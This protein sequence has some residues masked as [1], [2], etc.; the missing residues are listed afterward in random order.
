MCQRHFLKQ[1]IIYYNADKD[2]AALTKFKNWLLIFPTHQN[3]LGSS[4]NSKSIYVNNGKVDEY[5][6]WV[7]TLS[8]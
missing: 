5:A 7:K 6:S 8:L 4:F 2:E 1:G 3:L